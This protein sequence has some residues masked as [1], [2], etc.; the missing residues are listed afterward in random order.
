MNDMIQLIGQAQSGDSGAFEQ[1]VFMYQDQVYSN[2]MRLT[3][4]YSDAEDLAQEVFV[5]AY[6]GIKSFRQEA[7][8][9]TWLHRIAVNLWI[10]ICRKE[11]KVVTFSIDNKIATDD[12][13]MEREIEDDGVSLQEQIEQQDLGRQIQ[14][15]L[16]MLNEEFRIV[17]VLRYLE[18]YS[19]QEISDTIGVPLGTVKSR[20]SRAAKQL[21]QILQQEKIE[22]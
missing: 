19:Y 7:D 14:K 8:F 1:L 2:C 5:K 9:G 15:S 22:W 11:K 3:G 18:E 12:G 21:Q 10:N 6:T 16:K 17:L 13:D 4:N 20:I